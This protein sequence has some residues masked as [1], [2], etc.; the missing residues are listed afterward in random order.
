MDGEVAAEQQ[1]DQYQGDSANVLS[2]IVL[3]DD[4]KDC[5][6]SYTVQEPVQYSDAILLD[7]SCSYDPFPR[8][9]DLNSGDY[10]SAKDLYKEGLSI[11][12]DWDCVL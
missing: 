4:H 7:Q 6:G 3:W 9:E 10:R 8:S 5:E 12:G 2:A 11:L 1:P